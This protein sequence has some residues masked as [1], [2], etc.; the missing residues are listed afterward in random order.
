MSSSAQTIL[1]EPASRTPHAADTALTSG[2]PRPEMSVIDATRG[3]VVS[4]TSGA[5]PASLGNVACPNSGGPATLT[6]AFPD[7]R[8]YTT[9]QIIL[10]GWVQIEQGR[11]AEGVSRIEEGLSCWRTLGAELLRPYYLSLLAQ[12][13]AR[14]GQVNEGLRILDEALVSLS[15][16]ERWWEAELYRLKGELLLQT[17]V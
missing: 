9:L 1:P 10:H 14:K 15:S 16:T 4:G 3:C 12:G 11:N 6:M 13:Y 17:K 8:Q 2:N 5:M 7:L